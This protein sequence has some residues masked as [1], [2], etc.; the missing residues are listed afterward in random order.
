MKAM[1]RPQPGDLFYLPAWNS[2]EV[3]GLVIGRYIDHIEPNIGHLI[4]VFDRFY[5]EPP[6]RIEDVDRSRRLFRP[7]MWDMW[8]QKPYPR[9][10]ILFSDPTYDRSQSNYEHIAIA[11]HNDIWIGGESRKVP[12]EVFDTLEPSICW[13]THHLILRAIIHLAGILGPDDKHDY[14]R[15]PPAYRVDNPEAQKAVEALALEMDRR[16][17]VWQENEKKLKPRAK[18]P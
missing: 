14:H 6:V 10:K 17:Q 18:K 13:R 2:Q 12:K 4:E 9:W 7:V 11:W 15:L 16:F 8:F 5:V 3:Y 1:M